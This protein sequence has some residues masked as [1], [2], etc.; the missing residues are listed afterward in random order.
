MASTRCPYL[1]FRLRNEKRDNG[2]IRTETLMIEHGYIEWGMCLPDCILSG[3]PIVE[4]YRT[5][6]DSCNNCIII[7]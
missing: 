3:T 1:E 7:Y 6:S 4:P 2:V 5:Y